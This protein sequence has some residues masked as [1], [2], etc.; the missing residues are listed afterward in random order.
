MVMQILFCVYRILCVTVFLH[1]NRFFMRKKQIYI[2]GSI[3]FR[4]HRCLPYLW[5]VNA[6]KINLLILKNNNASYVK[7]AIFQ[8]QGRSNICLDCLV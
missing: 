5:C 3:V 6:N 2:L 4:Y 7:C 8:K 1:E